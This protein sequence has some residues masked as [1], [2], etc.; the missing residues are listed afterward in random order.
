MGP[1]HGR[2][3]P[4]QAE[5]LIRIGDEIGVSRVVCALHY[6][7]D[8]AAGQALGEALFAAVRATAGLSGRS[9]RR[10]R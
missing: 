7:S 8:V 9:G 6:P 2:G 1:H 4:D 3:P 10:P 5:A